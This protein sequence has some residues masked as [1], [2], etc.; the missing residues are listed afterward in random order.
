MP[1]TGQ[2]LKQSLIDKVKKSG[3]GSAPSDFLCLILSIVI[4]LLHF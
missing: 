1:I 2:V 3:G 4:L